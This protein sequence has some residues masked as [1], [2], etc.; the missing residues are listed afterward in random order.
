MKKVVVFVSL[1]GKNYD[2]PK[3]STTT[4]R[5]D[6]QPSARDEDY[7]TAGRMTAPRDMLYDK[8]M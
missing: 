1:R 4:D 3:F 7:A 6:P 8:S 2:I 5:L